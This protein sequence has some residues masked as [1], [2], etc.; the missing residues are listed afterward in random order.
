MVQPCSSGHPAALLQEVSP[1]AFA[2]AALEAFWPECG[3][4]PMSES[5]QAPEARRARA[6]LSSRDWVPSLDDQEGSSAGAGSGG[7]AAGVA[8][9]QGRQLKVAPLSICADTLKDILAQLASRD[10]DEGL[11]VVPSLADVRRW[12]LMLWIELASDRQRQGA[13]D[14][15]SAR[16]LLTA[17]QLG[18]SSGLLR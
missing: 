7:G 14:A 16:H 18:L 1:L 3:L 9:Q 13:Y 4:S 2:S 10:G 8:Q 11:G 6:L 17:V 5:D 15:P 12:A